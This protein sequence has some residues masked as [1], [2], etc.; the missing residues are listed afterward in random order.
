VNDGVVRRL[1]PDVMLLLEMMGSLGLPPLES[2]TPTEA[3]DFMAVSSAQ[4]A[5][6]PEVGEMVDGVLPG[7]GGDLNYRL[8]R[9]ATPGP[10]P[11]VVYYHGGGWV[12]GSHDS[13]DP[14][15]RDL[16]VRS[17]AL[18]ISVD[19]RHAPEAPF[20]AAVDDAFTALRWVADNAATLGGI[21]G[22]LAVA[23]WSAGGNLA[24]VVAQLAR[25]NGGPA[26]SGQLLLTPVTD[27][28][29]T[30]TSYRENGDG[31]ILT[32]PLMDWFWDHYIDKADRGDPRVA[33]LK[34]KSLAGLPPATIVTCEFDPLRDEG[35]AYAKA[36]TAAGV[37]VHHIAARGHTHTSIPAV[38]MLPSGAPLRAEMAAAIRGFF[39]ASVPA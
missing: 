17:G 21:P 27:S 39:G 2:M 16:C 4:R 6:G 20:P 13:D 32:A 1:Q 31:Y 37:P 29:L 33:P 19:Y 5:P 28:D 22:Q 7:A 9:P 15:C 3:R 34:A 18:I 8:Y 26:L 35:I 38:D 30:T 25:D 11:V 12:L 24:A 23:G 14:M 36:L 10:H